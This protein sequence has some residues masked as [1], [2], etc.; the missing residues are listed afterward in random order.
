MPLSA[1]AAPSCS[2]RTTSGTMAANTGQRIAMPMPL[3]KVR[4]SSSGA[5]SASVSAVMPS[6]TATSA[7][8]SCVLAK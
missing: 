3:A 8:Q 5:V 4:A 2:R 1:S 6:T 7:T